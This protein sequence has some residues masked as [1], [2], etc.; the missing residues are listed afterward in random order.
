MTFPKG[1]YHDGY[2]HDKNGNKIMPKS[3]RAERQEPPMQRTYCGRC[4]TCGTKLDSVLDGEEWC[5]KCQTYRRYQS[6]GWTPC[7]GDKDHKDANCPKA[8]ET[9]E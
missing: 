8:G 3:K 9:K 4:H 2:M 7:P 6:H 5:E 1:S